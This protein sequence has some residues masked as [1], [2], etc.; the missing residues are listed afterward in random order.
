MQ[1][2]QHLKPPAVQAAR[3]PLCTSAGQLGPA[4]TGCRGCRIG[5]TCRNDT[6]VDVAGDT[7]QLTF[8]TQ[9]QG[10]ARLERDTG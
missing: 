1:L 8:D 7:L 2:T 4:C 6:A 9:W 5:N 3:K 10:S